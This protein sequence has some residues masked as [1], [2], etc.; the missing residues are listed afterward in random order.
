MLFLDL[1]SLFMVDSETIHFNIK[2][3]H[4]SSIK[5]TIIK[6]NARGD[7]V[8]QENPSTRNISINTMEYL[9]VQLLIV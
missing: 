9:L 4:A 8:E 3:I 2:N 7:S 1:I 5:E 6:A